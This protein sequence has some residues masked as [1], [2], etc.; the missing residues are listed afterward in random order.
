[1]KVSDKVSSTTKGAR[2]VDFDTS[3][4]RA[5]QPHLGVELA[6]LLLRVLDVGSEEPDAVVAIVLA[7]GPPGELDKAAHGD[8]LG[9]SSG[10]DGEESTIKKMWCGGC[11]E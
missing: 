9:E 11:G 1:M 10:G 6:G 7:S 5:S 2:D 3:R 8:D 4:A